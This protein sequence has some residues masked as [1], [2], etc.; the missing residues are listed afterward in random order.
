M[1][2]QIQENIR[3]RMVQYNDSRQPTGDEVR[4]AWLISEIER[5]NKK[6]VKIKE[7]LLWSLLMKI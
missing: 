2:E 3:E 6:I 4:I 5:L 1:L 7:V